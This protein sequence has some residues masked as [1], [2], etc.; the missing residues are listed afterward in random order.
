MEASFI[1]EAGSNI[2]NPILE[3]GRIAREM[4]SQG[5]RLIKINIGDP[6]MYFQLPKNIAWAYKKA[7]D[8]GHT[9]YLEEQGLK[10]LRDAV[11]TRYEDL[12]GIS[13]SLDNVVV[14]QGVSEALSFMNQAMI[15]KGDSAVIFKPFFTE[16]L[17]YLKLSNGMGIFPS[18]D[19]RNGWDIDPDGLEMALK[20]HKGKKPKYMLITNPNNPTG[21]ALSEKGIRAAIEAAKDNDMYIVS[22]EVYDEML[23]DN[24]T[25]TSVGK[26]AKG[27]PH[28]LLNGASKNYMATGLRIGFA[29]FPEEDRKSASIKKAFLGMAGARLS[30]NTP[31]QY[32]MLEGLR[33]REKHQQFLAGKLPQISRQSELAYK[34]INET[35]FFNAV[36]PDSAFYLFARIN[37]DMLGIKD[38]KE[39][40]ELLLR[41]QNVQLT[42]GS[43]FG[44]PGF[45]RIVTLPSEAVLTDAINR[46]KRFCEAHQ[47]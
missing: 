1:S 5:S 41:E 23:H 39:F 9:S 25:F 37:F 32:A 47:R 15:D 8:E 13:F 7:I 3:Q 19:E 29:I 46:I 20:Y 4:E 16:Y 10:D 28:M 17:T 2:E 22:D 35:G 33:N 14:T 21:T 27:I 42:R 34:L 38:D 26:L 6:G 31:S 44:M 12:Y 40:V 24:A 45:I 18:L 30:A 36:K 11:S 43:G